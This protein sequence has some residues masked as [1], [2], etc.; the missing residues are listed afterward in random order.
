[1]Y[2]D[3]GERENEVTFQLRSAGAYS[4]SIAEKMLFTSC[5]E[6]GQENTVWSTVLVGITSR[7]RL[8]RLFVGHIFYD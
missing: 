8:S 5:S 4:S 7:I 6:D 1:M 3:G 2:M